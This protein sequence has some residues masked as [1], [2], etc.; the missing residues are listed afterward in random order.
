MHTHVETHT[1]STWLG[2][3][4]GLTIPTH[5]VPDCIHIW[6]NIHA[7]LHTQTH[8]HTHTHTHTM[9]ST[10]GIPSTYMYAH[11]NMRSYA[12][13]THITHAYYHVCAMTDVSAHAC[14]SLVQTNE[15]SYAGK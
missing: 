7:Y 2:D 4:S 5:V 14:T 1:C 13:Q 3:A 12:H 9:C 8:T 15:I 10:P 11:R 6:I